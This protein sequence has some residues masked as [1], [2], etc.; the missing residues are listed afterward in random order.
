MLRTLALFD[1]ILIET[2]QIINKGDSNM[3]VADK[4]YVDKEKELY[5]EMV[6]LAEK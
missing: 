4:R 3:I 5:P 1:I 2:N 6:V